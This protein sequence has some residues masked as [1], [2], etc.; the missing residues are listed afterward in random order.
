MHF[1]ER[2]D[3]QATAAI[4]FAV[5]ADVA[6]WSSWDP[7]VRSSSIDGAFVSGASGFLKPSKG[8]ESRI[9]FSE[10]IQ[11]SS[12]TVE[13]KLPFCLMKFEHELLSSPAGVGALHRVNFSG[14][15]APIFGR[16]IGNQIRN[17]LA[18]TMTGLKCAAE[19]ANNSVRD[20]PSTPGE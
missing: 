16:L 17:G 20:F 7:G 3:I 12:F 2:I 10:I 4:V 13:C 14:P 9:L 19:Q 5:Y 1:E 6:Q 18:H 8:P 15:L 11:D